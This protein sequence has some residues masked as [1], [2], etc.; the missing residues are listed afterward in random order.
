MHKPLHTG[1]L[2]LTPIDPYAAPEDIPAM[3]R[4]LQRI[5]FIDEPLIESEDRYVLGTHFMQLVTFMGCSP[6]IR[7]EPG[8]TGEPFCHLVVDGPS[9]QPRLLAGKNTRPPRCAAYRRRL[10]D[11]R[12]G[13]EPGSSSVAGRETRCPHCGHLQDPATYDFRQTAGCGRF[14]LLLEN[15]FPQ[16]AVPSPTL[17]DTLSDAAGSTPWHFFY[18]QE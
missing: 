16:E 5:G 11:W 6:F 14:F 1:R 18:Q 17:L 8:E 3:I 9:A 12:A 2:A 10:D 7:L 4:R 15:I 13:F